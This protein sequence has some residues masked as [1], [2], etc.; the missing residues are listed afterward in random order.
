M[1]IDKIRDRNGNI[2][3]YVLQDMNGV[4]ARFDAKD[5]KHAM[6]LNMLQVDNLK[7]TKDGKLIDAGNNQNAQNGNYMD[8]V[9]NLQPSELAELTADQI[10]EIIG[11]ICSKQLQKMELIPNKGVSQYVY[12]MDRFAIYIKTW[13]DICNGANYIDNP[14]IDIDISDDID[15]FKNTKSRSRA[16]SIADGTQLV[17]LCTALTKYMNLE[18]TEISYQDVIDAVSKVT[19]N[20]KNI[21]GNAKVSSRAGVVFG[22]RGIDFDVVVHTQI[23]K[24]NRRTNQEEIEG[25]KCV[26][27]FHALNIRVGTDVLNR[28]YIIEIT[29]YAPEGYPTFVAYDEIHKVIQSDEHIARYTRMHIRFN[30][31]IAVTSCDSH[32]YNSLNELIQKEKAHKIAQDSGLRIDINTLI[33]NEMQICYRHLTAWIESSI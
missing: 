21:M 19:Y 25:Y 13:H 26:F 33:N 3:G 31:E 16:I 24:G 17:Q 1:C 6:F 20:A 5:V 23:N 12:I 7:L 2:K 4:V 22:Y 15:P 9:K 14:H 18:K 11:N 30:G 28:C 29:R 8:R 27:P 10:A 32:S